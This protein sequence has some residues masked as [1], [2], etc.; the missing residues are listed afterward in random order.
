MEFVLLENNFSLILVDG[1]IMGT[2]L[3]LQYVL[4]IINFKDTYNVFSL[5]K[6]QELRNLFIWTLK[7]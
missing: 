3:L 6:N 4:K 5:V 7:S 2:V 1:V